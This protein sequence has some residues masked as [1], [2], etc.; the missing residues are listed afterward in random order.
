[1]IFVAGLA[2]NHSVYGLIV[3]CQ[4]RTLYPIEYHNVENENLFKNR[5]IE[6]HSA[7]SYVAP[8]VYLDENNYPVKYLYSLSAVEDS[9]IFKNQQIKI[10]LETETEINDWNNIKIEGLLNPYWQGPDEGVVKNFAAYGV[11]LSED[12]E[13]L[14]LDSTPWKWYWHMLII[15]IAGLF[16][17]RMF[18]AFIDKVKETK[19]QKKNQKSSDDNLEKTK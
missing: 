12:A 13:Y 11:I 19:V 15:F 10:V 3:A 4:N 5:Y 9:S 14:K 7:T 18:E 17:Y 16:F 8:L 6:L 1:M 2:L